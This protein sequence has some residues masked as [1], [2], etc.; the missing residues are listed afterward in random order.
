MEVD[1]TK[2]FGI[3]ICNDLRWDALLMLCVLRVHQDCT[4][5]S[6]SNVLGCQPMISWVFYKSVIR[7]VLE[8]GSVV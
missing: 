8:Y 5:L 1:V 2:L 4:F 6:Y 3:N 7:C